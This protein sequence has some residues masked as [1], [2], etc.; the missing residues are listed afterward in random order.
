MPNIL[1]V[2]A[3]QMISKNSKDRV[4]QNPGRSKMNSKAFQSKQKSNHSGTNEYSSKQ[5]NGVSGFQFVDNRAETIAQ[6]KLQLMA[7]E[8]TQENDAAQ[9]NAITGLP[10]VQRIAS[11]ELIDE[12]Y[13]Q[14][15]EK[16]S[17]GDLA[18]HTEEK[19]ITTVKKAL[20]STG[21]EKS[22]LAENLNAKATH[23]ES[24]IW[25]GYDIKENEK[26]LFENY[27]SDSVWIM[28]NNF[29]NRK[30][31]AFD[32]SAAINWQAEHAGFKHGPGFIVRKNVVNQSTNQEANQIRNVFADGKVK[33]EADGYS[34]L[35][36]ET[37]NGRHTAR[38]LTSH[39]LKPV[40][41]EIFGT[42][43][44]PTIVIKAEP[45]EWE[46]PDRPEKKLQEMIPEMQPEQEDHGIAARSKCCFLT[47]ACT[48]LKGLPDHCHELTVL[49]RFRDEY[50]KKLPEGEAMINEYYRVAPLIVEKMKLCPEEETTLNE[51]FKTITT[52][53]AYIELNQP[54]EALMAYK[55]M[56]LDLSEKYL[57]CFDRLNHPGIAILK[58]A[59]KPEA[60]GV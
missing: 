58:T 54:G 45:G 37:D 2:K 46:L 57:N 25:D 11:A 16:F 24:V 36:N 40:S 42:E 29:N 6:R 34:K 20:E 60:F 14:K 47:T 33:I 52:C 38:I 12:I 31:S 44:T 7:N 9:F 18:E 8:S 56:V 30:L 28:A 50:L 1:I 53:V 39:G 5:R 51:I 35:I 48:Q 15:H 22:E 10:V 26:L 55:T 21:A 49:R 3:K 13:A 4:V 59:A 19:K 41:A 27:Y 43:A 23:V 17:L 32:G